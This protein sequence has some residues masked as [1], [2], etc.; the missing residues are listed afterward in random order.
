MK[1]DLLQLLIIIIQDGKTPLDRGKGKQVI[2][3]LEKQQMKVYKTNND[4][5]I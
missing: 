1:N 4:Y 2:L 3:V 5:K